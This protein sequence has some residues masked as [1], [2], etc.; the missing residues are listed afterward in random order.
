MFE[1][2]SPIRESIEKI[3]L[4]CREAGAS[5]WETAKIVKALRD[6]EPGAEPQ[7]LRK[8]A[9]FLLRE[10]NSKAAQTYASFNKLNVFVSSQR[11]EAFDR[12]NIAKSLLR[13]TGI[14]RSLA[15]KI[16]LE[17]EDKIKDLNLNNLNTA[18]IREMAD[19]KLLE[20]GLEEFHKNYSRQGM[21]AY[22]IGAALESGIIPDESG[23]MEEYAIRNLLSEEARK[24]HF[25]KDIHI[26]HLRDYSTKP[27]AIALEPEKGGSAEETVAGITELLESHKRA[28]SEM[29]SLL[30]IN[31]CIAGFGKGKKQWQIAS[32]SLRAISASAG[33][34]RV[35]ACVSLFSEKSVSR[36][37]REGE[38]S[39]ALELLEQIPVYAG[40]LP[41]VCV[42]SHHQLKL[43]GEKTL[44]ALAENG[45]LFVQNS[46]E[47]QKFAFSDG[48]ALPS[49]VIVSAIAL[50]LE[51]IAL[52][53]DGQ[54][55]SFHE[56]ARERAKCIAECFGQRREI[57]SK[58][59]Y[60]KAEWIESGIDAVQVTL[61]R[62]AAT[63]LMGKE[64]NEKEVGAFCE[65]AIEKISR[66]TGSKCAVTG[67]SSQSAQNAF[68]KSNSLLRHEEFADSADECIFGK[69]VAGNRAELADL[70]EKGNEIVEFR[71]RSG[72]EAV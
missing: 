65:K 16:A 6:E 61:P 38:N 41:V 17:V 63:A 44:E 64:A 13:E 50:N 24:M 54:I 66:E 42:N 59:N 39:A 52:L 18:L 21:P 34:R 7:R 49:R 33:G 53:S 48:S 23:M 8:K 67:I 57:L 32:A 60:L 68:E 30:G 28:F 31:S 55:Q 36:E 14:S 1:K 47:T 5:E 27:C 46:G 29:P 62:R 15:E 37:E 45:A 43:A 10:M 56:L 72:T 20:Y 9:V 19:V 25:G 22:E 3:A 12:G 35:S 2:Q 11:I 58:K 26:I 71:K 40:M 4:E 69:A 70:L 51:R